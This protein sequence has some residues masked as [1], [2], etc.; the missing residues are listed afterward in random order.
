MSGAQVGDEPGDGRVFGEADPFEQAEQRR[1]VD[2]QAGLDA[3]AESGGRRSAGA[4]ARQRARRAQARRHRRFAEAEHELRLAGG[5][6]AV[7]DVQHDAAGRSASRR[8]PRRCPGSTPG[9]TDAPGPAQLIG[10]RG[11]GGAERAGFLEAITTAAFSSSRLPP[12]AKIPAEPIQ[13]A[14]S[15]RACAVGAPSASSGVRSRFQ[16][17][18]HA[19]R[20][21][22]GLLCPPLPERASERRRPRA[23]L[24]RRWR[25]SCRGGRGRAARELAPL[26]GQTQASVLTKLSERR[27]FVYL[28]RALPARA[29]Q[30]V[31]ALKL[32]GVAGTSVMRR[33]YPRG[34][35]AAQVLGVVGAEGS[36]LGRASSTRATSSSP[37]APA[38]GVWSATRA[39]SRC[40]S[41]K[42]ARRRR[43]SRCR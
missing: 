37:A 2:D 43:A 21:E 14:N 18:L 33:V 26:L 34:T 39:A 16:Q 28:A 30:S 17:R 3:F 12:L 31:L 40:R 1:E 4:R 13:L 22:L 24:R 38:G 9:E 27:G 7:G 20:P 42:P 29:A 15:R 11:D 10:E 41:P 23:A 35:L 19:E 36:G 25:G 32:A 5:V 8:P 6:A